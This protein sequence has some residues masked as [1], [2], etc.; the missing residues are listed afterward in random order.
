MLAQPAK[1]RIFLATSTFFFFRNL[2][3]KKGGKKK[4]NWWRYFFLMFLLYDLEKKKSHTVPSWDDGK[5]FCS[6]F[7]SWTSCAHS[8]RSFILLEAQMF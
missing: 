8:V 5:Q 4:M 3:E 7:K 6:H 1:Y 2:K